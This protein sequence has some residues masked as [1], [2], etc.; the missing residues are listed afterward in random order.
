MRFYAGNVWYSVIRTDDITS[1][2]T[3]I[4]KYAAWNNKG[5]MIDAGEVAAN[6]VEHVKD[7]LTHYAE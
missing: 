1:E 4:F 3:P 5:Q 7:I 2:G 6:C